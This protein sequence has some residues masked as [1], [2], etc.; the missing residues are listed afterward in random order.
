MKLLLKKVEIADIN[1]SY[2]GTKKDILI[3]DGIVTE[4]ADNID[5]QADKTVDE[6]DLVVSTGWVD[7]FT[8]FCDP[9]FEYRETLQSGA[10]AAAAGGFTQ[11]FILPN[12]QPQ[13]QSKTQ[14]EYVVEKSKALPVSISPLG[15]I[16]KNI[17]GKELAEMYDMKNSGAAAFSDGLHPVQ[18]SGLLLKALQYVKAF[19][20]VIVQMP[21]DKSIGAFGLMNEGII[22]TQLG[23]PGIPAIAEEM[24]VKRDIDLLKYT[25]SKLHITGVSTAKTVELIS[26]AKAEGLQITCSVTPYHLMYCDEN[27]VDY[28]TNL[29]INPPLRSRTD[30]MAL[31]Q[32][33]LDGK[34][35]CITSHHLPQNWDSKTCEFEYAKSGMIGLQTA[36]AAINELLP[37]LSGTQLATL[38]SSNAR[39]IFGLTPA[40]IQIGAVAELTLFTKQGQTVLIKENNKSKSANSSLFNQALQGTVLGIYHKSQ[41]HLN[42]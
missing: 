11:V 37:G 35:D 7:I 13:I 40:T 17:E 10:T 23:L 30:M 12:T 24:I 25:E 18:S 26:N 9:G 41:L 19:D 39:H 38:F 4:I 22:S 28:D 15:A 34:I 33:V 14:V 8:H 21:I 29:K 32:A 16:T 1:S 6:T 36:F 20:G 2:N 31:R 5:V 3:T 42:N 27:L